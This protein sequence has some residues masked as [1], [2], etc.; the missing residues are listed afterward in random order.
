MLYTRFAIAG[1]KSHSTRGPSNASCCIPLLLA[2]QHDTVLI[3]YEVGLYC[4]SAS[5]TL[6]CDGTVDIVIYIVQLRVLE[7]NKYRLLIGVLVN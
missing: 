5:N 7:N 6:A 1:N 2:F 4:L 3:C